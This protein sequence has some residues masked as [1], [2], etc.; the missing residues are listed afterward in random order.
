MRDEAR[1]FTAAISTSR[2]CLR[3]AAIKSDIGE[4]R[5]VGVIQQVQRL[6]TVI[7]NVEACDICERRTVVY[8][9]R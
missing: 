2:L 5:L 9:L 8:R 7:E 6:F 4:D 3:C 1:L